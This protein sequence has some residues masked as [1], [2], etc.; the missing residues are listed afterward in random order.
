MV[1]LPSDAVICLKLVGSKKTLE[2]IPKSRRR[3]FIITIWLQEIA[4][5]ISG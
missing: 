5:I 4:L 2:K 1:W 3:R